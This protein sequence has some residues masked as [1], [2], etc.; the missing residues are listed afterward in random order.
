MPRT[1]A[2]AAV[3]LATCV[4][5]FHAAY[6]QE[7][8]PPPLPDQPP[9]VYVKDSGVAVE[10]LALAARLERQK[11]WDKAADVYQD[12][13]TKFADR[14]IASKQD[15]RGQ[16]TQYVSA[17]RVVQ[18][19]LAKWPA[20][21]LAAYRR[22]FEDVARDLFNSED[23]TASAKLLS[24]YFLTDAGRDAA[25]RDAS[26]DFER[27]DF[28]AAAALGGRLLDTHPGLA[29]DRPRVL[30]QTGLAEHL[31]G[32]N[33]QAVKRLDEL[34]N[35]FP[36]A[37]AR[38]G[39]TDV[40][41]VDVLRR[42][43]ATFTPQTASFRSDDWSSPYGS[44]DANAV[45]AQ[46]S[47]G[48]AKLFSVELAANRARGINS[49][50]SRQLQKMTADARRSGALTGILP[51]IDS[52]ALF[53]Q[54]NA[55]VYAIDLGSGQPLP[56]WA[57]SYN[58]EKRG[59]FVLDANTMPTP[60]SRQTAVA[61]VGDRVIALLGQ[62]NPLAVNA[63]VYGMG[64]AQLVCLDRNTGRRNWAASLQQRALPESAANLRDGQ[65]YGTPLVDSDN[66]Y[67]LV[68]ANRGQQ[69]DECYVV[70]FDLATGN[71]KWATYVASAS[72]GNLEM[73]GGELMSGPPASVS[74]AGGRLFVLTNLGALACLS[75]DDGRTQWLNIYGRTSPA[76]I[77]QRA[78]RY[79]PQPP[80]GAKP[81]E[82]G[83][84][85]IA[86][87]N[88]F[89]LPADATSI[90]VYN[91]ADGTPV[92]TLP[93]QP[94]NRFPQAS[95]IV[96]IAGDTMVLANQSTLFRLP[97]KTFDT[98]KTLVDN[99]GLYKKITPEEGDDR[100]PEDS[101]R[102][103]PFLSAKS[104]LVT[105]NE[106][107]YRV[108]LASFKVDAFYPAQGKWDTD[109]S[110]GNIVA[111][112]ENLVIAGPSRVTV[113]AD[114]SVATAKL[115]ARLA[116]DANDVDASLRYADLL[117][118]AGQSKPAMARLDDAAAHLGGLSSMTPGVLRDRFFESA[119]GYAT[120]LQRDDNSAAVV[121]VLFDHAA[122]AA[123]SPMQQ[124]RYRVSRAAFLHQKNDIAG[125]LGL[126]QQI[127]A[128]A[129]WRSVP[130][131]GKGIPSSAGAEAEAAVTELVRQN[132]PQIYASYEVAAADAL[133][134]VQKTTPP[135][136]DAL[137]AIA[138]Q[139]PASR[140]TPDALTSAADRFEETHQPRRATQ[141]LRRLLKRDLSNER[142][143]VA[144]QSLARN[145]LAVPYQA[146]IAQVRLRQAKA[147]AP[148]A[149]LTAPL[150][151][152]DGKPLPVTTVAEALTE[153]E[154]YR[155]D[156]QQRLL[157]KLGIP[158]AP[159]DAKGAPKPVLRPAVEVAMASA[160]VEQQ[161]DLVRNDRVIT[162]GLDHRVGVIAGDSGKVSWTTASAEDTPVGCGF[163][164][165]TLIVVA[166][167][168]VT[169]V[170]A[171]GATLWKT[172]LAVLPAIDVAPGAPVSDTASKDED[173]LPPQII[174]DRRGQINRRM[175]L[176]GGF[177]RMIN[178]VDVPDKDSPTSGVERIVQYRLL[179][180][181]V[182]VGTSLGRVVALDLATGV[183]IWQ[184]RASD[185][186]VSRLPSNDD[187]IAVSFADPPSGSSVVVFDA[188]SGQTILNK[189]YDGNGQPQAGGL[190]NLALSPDGVLITML[191]S[192][193]IGID[194]YDLGSGDWKQDASRINRG[195]APFITSG[196]DGQ[197]V[198]TGDRVLVVYRSNGGA[199][200]ARAFSLRT[201]KP[202][203][204]P[205][206]RTGQFA[207]VPYG[208]KGNDPEGNPLL[209]AAN[210]SHFYLYGPRSLAQ[211]DLDHPDQTA[212]AASQGVGRG[213]TRDVVLTQDYVLQINQMGVQNVATPA[214]PTVQL[215]MYSRAITPSGVE[216]GVLDQRPIV[217]D[218]STILANE[219]QVTDGAFYYIS[220]DQKLKMVQVNH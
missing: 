65:F 166:G 100:S 136:A 80:S 153:I 218:L 165:E 175:I 59:A 213:P 195:E 78:N 18:D 9:S 134:T 11:D 63:S 157:P 146:A 53:F 207:E 196:Q 147:F 108:G 159:A 94:D 69:F 43:L 98:S 209:I 168:D 97:W 151:L 88:V 62:Y 112:P 169:A 56:G 45:P 186:P 113:Y 214:L 91:A 76:G 8:Q 77:G 141:T 204:A 60:Q 89:V 44:L 123:S 107:L 13:A 70:A 121:N 96:G 15:E 52:G 1:A 178:P 199:Q 220:G 14:L 105:T 75:A 61:V 20:E 55:R 79:M 64:G 101:I 50:Q 198:L 208:S 24:L 22:R 38:A 211:Y 39:G 177:R 125:E 57:Q 156:A 28:A 58:G 124:V 167:P 40:K 83:P 197:L 138:D 160:I 163:V 154:K 110:A 203:T 74:M 82:L 172:S 176:R 184:T 99:G 87:G 51:V 102:G 192:R 149:K 143:Q 187:F 32:Q 92:R 49:D 132:G 4:V 5:C 84:P 155:N 148:D 127:L 206:P 189:T 119:I 142:R 179:S 116:A 120:K 137:L 71:F 47:L 182:V 67:S 68:T 34:R 118:A 66:V 194:L 109:E 126:H 2:I 12:I 191:S 193:L 152:P 93:R 140:L 145:H 33:D 29:A 73:G 30:L 161:A 95:S 115:D 164:G 135:D 202:I 41:A 3:C 150:V 6:A 173:A 26:V 122:A 17:A 200:S 205:D 37:L 31:A 54:D 183:P 190:V 130:A 117:F 216:S 86:D 104:I 129:D 215:A 212:W 7:D 72:L 48:G 21:G 139:Y 27:G 210:G 111:T 103:R 128:R 162:Y 16:P 114:L 217:R 133:A 35:K 25:L 85:I 19:Q 170:N 201:L 42:E 219:W 180:D 131:A 10:R 144:L 23:P 185:L 46:V 106:R 174:F 171:A 90:Y 81:F 188:V 36:D 181:R 158:T